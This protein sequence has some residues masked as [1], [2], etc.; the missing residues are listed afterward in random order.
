MRA[1]SPRRIRCRP[2]AARSMHFGFPQE[3]DVPQLIAPTRRWSWLHPEEADPQPIQA[4]ADLG[5]L[6]V[7]VNV[8]GHASPRWRTARNTAEADRL[9]QRLSE[10]RAKNIHAAV[11]E[12]LKRELPSLPIT[13]SWKGVGSHDG[14]P[15]VGDDNPAVDRSVM[16]TLDL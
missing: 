5:N 1:R 8:V 3:D 16:V 11:E 13:V 2:H 4:E 10:M 9:N 14:F 12:I 15:T 7:R 6:A